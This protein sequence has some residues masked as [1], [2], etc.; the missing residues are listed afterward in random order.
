MTQVRL[1]LWGRYVY[2]YINTYTYT[3]TIRFV[4]HP[5]ESQ[6]LPKGF[7]KKVVFFGEDLT[8]ASLSYSWRKGETNSST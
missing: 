2:T 8:G 5:L 3:Y 4:H 1:I 7:P 6:I